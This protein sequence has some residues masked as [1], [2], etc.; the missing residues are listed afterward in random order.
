MRQ[1]QGSSEQGWG[2]LE[3]TGAPESQI[4]EPIV[5]GVPQ[6]KSRF[7]HRGQRSER[8]LMG[9]VTRFTQATVWDIMFSLFIR[10]R[11]KQ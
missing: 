6:A 7:C 10:N 9:A 5:H 8:A 11:I 2:N 1:A 4:P 3:H